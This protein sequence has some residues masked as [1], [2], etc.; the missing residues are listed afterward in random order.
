MSNDKTVRSNK[1]LVTVVAVIIWLIA[2]FFGVNIDDWTSNDE[3]IVTMIDVGQ[4]DCFLLEQDGM[5][6]LVDCGLGG[7][8]ADEVIAFLKQKG[9]NRLDYV[10]GTH[11]HDDHMGG[12]NKII[13]T[14][15]IGTIIIPKVTKMKIT[16]A[17]YT[18]LMKEIKDGV[19]DEKNPEKE[20]RYILDYPEVGEVYTLGKATIKVLGPIEEPKSNKNNYSTVLMVTL[21]DF[22][23]LM[24]GDAE[25]S[26]ENDI[27]E[28]GVDLKAE[29]L[30]V[31]HHGSDTS[32]GDKFLDAVD[33]KYALIS[34]G[35][36]N[37]HEH[38]IESVMDKLEERDIEV[39][40]TDESGT[41]VLT[42][43]GD[44]VTFNTD[45]DDYLS[46]V[47]LAEKEGVE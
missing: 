10:F 39:Y 5:V 32:T 4:A 21:G 34:A 13:T 1:L 35:L 24:T 17:W 31:G 46:G 42:I 11:P 20:V 14:F 43:T 33:P 3:L 25:I 45:P 7:T 30:K 12:M 47:E 23:I 2:T 19:Y 16:T 22:D 28:T 6:A 37:S 9:I 26:L 38:P 29:I 44:S 36:G 40:R 41:V 18:N 27:L 15:E 8:T